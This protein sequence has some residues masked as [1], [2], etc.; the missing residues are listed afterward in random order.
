MDTSNFLDPVWRINNLY[1]IID[2]RGRRVL[3][4]PNSAQSD[5]LQTV[6]RRDLI[7][8]ARQLG[9]TTLCCII[10][11]D[12]ALFNDDW[13]VAIIAHKLDDA[14]S[15]F[16]TKVRYPYDNLHAAIKGRRPT[17]KDAADE[18]HFANN[19]SIAVTNSA[20]SGTLQRLHVS[21]FG[22]ICAQFPNKAREIVTGSFPAAEH[23]SI[24]IESTAEGQEGK[25]FELAQ[26]AQANDGKALTRKDWRFHFYPWHADPGNA[27][28]PDDVVITKEDADYFGKLEMDGVHL[29]PAQQAWWVK[30]EK[31]LGG[32]MKRENPATALEAFEQAIEGAYFSTQLAHATKHGFIGR[33][34]YD[35]RYPVN[36]FWDLGRNDL[37]TIWLHQRVGQRN[38][39][40][41]FYENSGEH[42]S[43]YVRWL[44]DWAKPY[45][46][47]FEEHY[48]PHDG[49]RQDLFL[50]NGRLGEAEKLGFKPRIVKRARVKGEAID[51]ARAAFAT[52]DFDEAGC[53]VGLKRLRQYRKDWD[54]TRGVWRDHP[55]H[56]ENSHGADSFQTFACG[57][58][59]RNGSKPITYGKLANVA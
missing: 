13:R 10:G 27:L 38:R 17:I 42:I 23:G 37:N 2:K 15:I 30:T 35:P 29:T 12:E 53:S 34:P 41:G 22:K 6:G 8:K 52:C 32:D 40:I 51:A 28:C 20:R 9:F 33:F 31:D 44:K 39:F 14:K 16:Q 54:E 1:W 11:L 59:P 45:D 47:R 49:D 57:Y 19:S 18:L 56:D 21:E 4:Q 26:V 36:T 5:F 55:R 58:K 3:F 25:F 48:W 43:H 46:A 7:L 50:E 24:T